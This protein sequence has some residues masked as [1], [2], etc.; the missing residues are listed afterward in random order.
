MGVAFMA[1]PYVSCA[2]L[3]ARS[4]GTPG[5]LTSQRLSRESYARAFTREFERKERPSVNLLP[6]VH[7]HEVEVV[8]GNLRRG[9]VA[10]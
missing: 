6:L 9:S 2:T 5:A 10:F 7:P 4:I 8:L 1:G 3:P